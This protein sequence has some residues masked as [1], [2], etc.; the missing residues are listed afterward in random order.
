MAEN[1]WLREE[2]IL[3]LAKR[4][5]EVVP[6]AELSLNLVVGLTTPETMKFKGFISEQDL[7]IMVDSIVTHN[8]ISPISGATKTINDG[9]HVLWCGYGL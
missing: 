9:N 7:M 2:E 5:V 3:G 8:F 6:C 1:M 4:E